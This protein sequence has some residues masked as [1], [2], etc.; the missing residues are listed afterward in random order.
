VF[1]VKLN[2]ST[3]FS[4]F[5]SDKQTMFPSFLQP[6]TKDTLLSPSFYWREP[7]TPLINIVLK[8]TIP[9]KL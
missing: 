2:I 4:I 6:V 1:A 8:K 9:I 7:K 3:Q 5:S